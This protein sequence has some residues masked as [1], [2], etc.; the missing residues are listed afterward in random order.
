MNTFA[1]ALP[2]PVACILASTLAATLASNAPA[3]LS[4]ERLYYG[5]NQPIN[6]RVTT[7]DNI[8]I[9]T[10]I[11]LQRPD[12]SDIKV[13]GVVPGVVNLATMFPEIW[14][15]PI[16]GVWYAQLHV[17]IADIGAPIVIQ[18]L[19]GTGP[20]QMTDEAGAIALKL[21]EKTR[22][23]NFGTRNA[24]ITY[25]QP[26]KLLTGVRVYVDRV[27]TM[28]TSLG[29]IE[30]AMRPDAAP[31]TVFNFLHL[32]EGGFYTGVIFHRVVARLPNGNAFVI[33]TGDPTG[34]GDGG[35]GFAIDLEPSTLPHDFGV[36]SMARD[37]D[38]NTNGSQI[39][40]ALSREGTARLDGRYTAFAQALSGAE[41]IRK[42]AAVQV[43]E[44][45]RPVDPPVI[46]AIRLD[47]APP[48]ARRRPL[49]PEVDP[50][51]APSSK[52]TDAPKAGPAQPGDRK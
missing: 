45:D 52:P 22:Q 42:I 13:A 38:P 29:D 35:P 9:D 8:E 6:I 20:A 10:A 33:Q 43:G 32:A 41:V 44:N 5:V 19:K 51:Q 49:T 27:A 4:P 2:P 48:L 24:R 3:Q 50:G 47:Q 7:P 23:A 15:T 30:F 28:Q 25:P 17:G 34:T 31:N 14:T 16:D 26:D 11:L 40:V 12:G 21:D 39:F 36:L 46:R 18:P 37:D 1:R